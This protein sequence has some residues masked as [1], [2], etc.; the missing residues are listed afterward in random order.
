MKL[1]EAVREFQTRFVTYALVEAH[2]NIRQ[3]ARIIGKSPATMDR[4]VGVLGLRDYARHLRYTN[5]VRMARG[6]ILALAVAAALTYAA[7]PLT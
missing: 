4:W 3:A 1:S 2:G 6:A 7:L 5:Y